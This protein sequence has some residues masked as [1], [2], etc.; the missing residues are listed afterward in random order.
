MTQR[1]ST[2]RRRI[3]RPRHHEGLRGRY[4]SPV[5]A[6]DEFRGVEE[7]AGAALEAA[8]RPD[9]RQASNEQAEIEAADVHQEA[10]PDIGVPRR[11]TLRIRPVS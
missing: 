8:R 7:G 6:Q 4:E 11:C 9:A 2:D 1:R 5:A 3:R 10:L